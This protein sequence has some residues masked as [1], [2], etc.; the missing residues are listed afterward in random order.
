MS[1]KRLREVGIVNQLGELQSP[2]GHGEYRGPPDVG[3]KETSGDDPGGPPAQRRKF[4]QEPGRADLSAEGIESDKF[5][6]QEAIE[7]ARC[8]AALFSYFEVRE[9]TS[10]YCYNIAVLLFVVFFLFFAFCFGGEGAGGGGLPPSYTI[11]N[12]QHMIML[13]GEIIRNRLFRDQ[14]VQQ[15]P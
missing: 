6:L 7:A 15:V 10:R 4:Q 11:C 1:K 12:S 5:A 13:R 14:S 9:L 8:A 3:G 2:G